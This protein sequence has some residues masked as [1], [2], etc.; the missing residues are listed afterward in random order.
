MPGRPG[1]PGRGE[2]WIR[3]TQITP[4]I[5][6]GTLR[7]DARGDVRGAKFYIFNIRNGQYVTVG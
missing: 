1:H 7:F 2:P 5:L 6:G 3:R 4:S